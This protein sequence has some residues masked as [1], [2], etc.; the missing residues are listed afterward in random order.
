M[1]ATRPWKRLRAERSGREPLRR[2]GPPVH[3][4]RGLGEL[5]RMIRIDPSLGQLA[6]V[7]VVQWFGNEPSMVTE[8]AWRMRRCGTV[9]DLT[10]N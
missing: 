6:T 9:V 1:R 5:A 10:C 2:V 4:G 7:G 3:G 8:W